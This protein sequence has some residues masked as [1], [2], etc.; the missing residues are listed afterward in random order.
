MTITK[1]AL[2]NFSSARAL[3][4]E[5]RART[6]RQR[7]L[8]SVKKHAGRCAA[9]AFRRPS[10]A[11]LV[12]YLQSALEPLVREAGLELPQPLSRAALLS[13]VSAA[14][15][16][17]AAGSG[18]FAFRASD[19]AGLPTTP[20]SIGGP[21]RPFDP[22]FL[23]AVERAQLYMQWQLISGG[24]DCKVQVCPESP[25]RLRSLLR[26]CINS[27]DKRVNTGFLTVTC[28]FIIF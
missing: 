20:A 21:Q 23:S 2:P 28:N 25:D 12:D 19:A 8:L 1:S 3:A 5:P 11:V 4:D 9:L 22:A 26:Y 7:V 10:N 6:K 27:R 16:G 14:F 15:A 13:S 24:D 18:G 17:A